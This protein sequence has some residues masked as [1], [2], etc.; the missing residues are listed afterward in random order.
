M[1]TKPSLNFSTGPVGMSRRVKRVLKKEGI[2]HRSDA[3][4]QL[5]LKT[6]KALCV[7][8]KAHF[9]QILTGS[10][11]LAND[12]MVG[13]L[14]ISREKG[15]ILSNGDFGKRLIHQCQRQGVPFYTYSVDYC[16]A[17]DLAAIENLLKTHTDIRWILFAHCETSV[18]FINPLEA[19]C[20]LAQQYQVRVNVDLMS[21]MGCMALDLST[22]SLATASS[23]KGL[24]SIAGLAV[25][26]SDKKLVSAPDLPSYLDLGV[27]FEKNGV[28]FTLSPHLL[29]ALSEQ[30]EVVMQPEHWRKTQQWSAYLSE[31][32]QK[33]SFI[34]LLHPQ[35]THVFTLFLPQALDNPNSAAQLGTFLQTQ[36]IEV[37]FQSDALH[38]A[39][40]LQIALMCEHTER[41][42]AFLIKSIKAYQPIINQRDA[43]RLEN[44]KPSNWL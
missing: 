39:N 38:Q 15:L 35:K 40:Y 13:Q 11:T 2:S 8:T 41:D 16:T 6:Q 9:A 36:G 19:L 3:F 28:P 24:A 18:G 27:Y 42:L 10:G 32:L 5:L 14:K 43:Y 22:V 7:G 31:K 34:Q 29:E 17:F 37:S 1:I 44:F 12:V 26:F 30:V 33:I 4:Q 25:L 21:S 20:A 23:G